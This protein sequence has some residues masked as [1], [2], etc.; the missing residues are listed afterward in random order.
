MA[1]TGHVSKVS[2]RVNGALHTV[3]VALSTPLV[4]VLRNQIGLTG[5]KVGCGL[6]QCGSCAVLVDGEPTLSCVAPVADFIGCEI[7]TVEGLLED[8]AP[9]SVQRA[10][11]ADGAAQCGYCTPGLVIAVT[12][13]LRRT[14]KPEAADIAAALHGHLCRCGAHLRV[15]KAIDRLIEESPRNGT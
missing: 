13:L 10:F 7:E 6:E 1:V 2:L 3:E 8:G 5:A 12:G 14:P 11:I 15:L 4:F 9:G